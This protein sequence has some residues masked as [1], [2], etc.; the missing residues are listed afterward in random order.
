MDL[1]ERTI[2]SQ[3]LGH[4]RD[5]GLCSQTMALMIIK[6][7]KEASTYNVDKEQDGKMVLGCK[8]IKSKVLPNSIKK[9]KKIYQTQNLR[10]N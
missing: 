1:R 8:K 2:D 10:R 7:K 4:G 3:E 9:T 6:T 5:Q